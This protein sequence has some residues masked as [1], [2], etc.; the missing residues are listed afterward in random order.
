VETHAQHFCE[1]PKHFMKIR[2]IRLS[3]KFNWI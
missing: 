3:I 2:V 1:S